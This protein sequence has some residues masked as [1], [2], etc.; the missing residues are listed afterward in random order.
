MYVTWLQFIS[1]KTSGQWSS[2]QLKRRTFFHTDYGPLNI[3]SD[4]WL[5]S[6]EI[7]RFGTPSSRFCL[8]KTG[9]NREISVFTSGAEGVILISPPHLYSGV[10]LASPKFYGG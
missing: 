2:V 6:G 10:L 4:V 3:G 1:D 7:L 8:V 9:E 5:L